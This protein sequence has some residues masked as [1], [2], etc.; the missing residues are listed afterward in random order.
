MEYARVNPQYHKLFNKCPPNPFNSVPPTR[1][2]DVLVHRDQVHKAT[3]RDSTKPALPRDP[4]NIHK[5]QAANITP[6]QARLT[7]ANANNDQA[8]SELM[9][10]SDICQG[11]AA[12]DPAVTSTKR[13]RVARVYEE[14][15]ERR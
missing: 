10:T 6:P 12:N 11:L 2:L 9:S 5:P 3:Y 8:E 7:T 15:M 14:E 4:H 13:L 1:D